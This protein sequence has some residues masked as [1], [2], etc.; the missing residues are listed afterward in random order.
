MV[1]YDIVLGSVTLTKLSPSQPDTVEVKQTEIIRIPHYFVMTLF[2][3]L[4]NSAI[5]IGFC[6]ASWE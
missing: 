3:L 1:N 4:F 2:G 6:F 5:F